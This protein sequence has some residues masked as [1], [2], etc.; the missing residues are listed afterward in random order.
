MDKE[1]DQIVL[2]TLERFQP[3]GLSRPY[4][5]NQRPVHATTLG[6]NEDRVRGAF[7]GYT[8]VAVNGGRA[9]I[10]GREGSPGDEGEN[11]VVKKSTVEKKFMAA[12]TASP[13]THFVD[14][15]HRQEFL[16][17]EASIPL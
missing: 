3:L 7:T 10:T 16:S 14:C 13:C 6:G 11:I 8:E 12:P 4:S 9:A 5:G 2:A 1:L 17:C 15:V